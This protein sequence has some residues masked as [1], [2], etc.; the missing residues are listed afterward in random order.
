MANVTKEKKKVK[1]EDIV[2]PE[3][4]YRKPEQVGTLYVFMA[5]F[6][7]GIITLLMY[8]FLKWIFELPVLSPCN[9]TFNATEC[10]YEAFVNF[11][12][13]DRT[14]LKNESCS[15]QCIK[16]AE[17][18]ECE[19]KEHCIGMNGELYDDFIKYCTF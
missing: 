17:S 19:Y 1:S 14:N 11:C 4:K 10:D 15:D 16:Y 12:D 5:F 9:T 13:S 2:I 18:Y 7:A 3:K 6:F 8:Y